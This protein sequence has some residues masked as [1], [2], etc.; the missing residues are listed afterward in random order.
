MLIGSR[1][2][3]TKIV[4]L[5][6]GRK[7]TEISVHENVLF[8]ASPVFKTAFTSSFRESSERSIYLPDDSATIMDMLV[9]YL[10]APESRLTIIGTI[11]QSLRLYVLADKYDIVKVKNKICED[12]QLWLVYQRSLSATGKQCSARPPKSAVK[13]VYENTT[14]KTPMRRLLVD[15]FVWGVDLAWFNNEENRSWLLSVPE[16]AVDVCA[17]LS[18]DS[19]KKAKARPFM[20]KRS[21][22][23]EE[24]PVGD[25]NPID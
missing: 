21:V 24:E 7:K 5:V 9:Q 13:F 10:Y 19:D 18:K 16:F 4:L 14:S 15:W 20:K 1:F 23:L 11:M 2:S 8:E 3:N 12:V 17:V 22:Y 25:R 6:V